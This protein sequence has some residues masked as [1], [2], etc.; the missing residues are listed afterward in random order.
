M[1][2]KGFIMQIELKPL[3]LSD[4]ET[5]YEFF[6]KLPASENGKNNRAHG[7]S[8]EDFAK[9]VQSEIDSSQGKNL[10]PGYVPGTTY[11]MYVDGTPVGVSNLR[12]YLN[13]NLQKDGGHIGTHIL[14]EYRGRGFGNIIKLE[15]LKKAKE[16][17]INPALVFNHDDNVPAWRTSEKLGGKLES[18]NIVN[19]VK[20]RKYVIDT[21]KL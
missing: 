12:H 15:T 1:I 10:K 13:E 7:L 5:L 8:K 19:G 14:P 18:I 21:S 16:M 11:V 4:A 6:Q 9:W 20:L 3:Q 17:G 2:P